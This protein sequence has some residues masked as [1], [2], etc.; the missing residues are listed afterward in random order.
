[1]F[2]SNAEMALMNLLTSQSP[3]S[4]ETIRKTLQWHRLIWNQKRR[5]IMNFVT[6]VLNPRPPRL[7]PQALPAQTMIIAV[8]CP[9]K[10]HF[11][12]IFAMRWFAECGPCVLLD[13]R[14]WQ[15]P[16]RF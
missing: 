12:N 15:E 3:P 11:A 8:A 16:F 4:E 13:Y 14:V 5:A 9:G 7:Q 10:S 6:M 1:M 2:D